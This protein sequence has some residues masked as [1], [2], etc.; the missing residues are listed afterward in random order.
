[1]TTSLKNKA[2][3]G[4]SWI[5]VGTLGQNSLQLLSLMV[6][7]RLLTPDEFGVVSVALVIIGFLRIFTELGVGPAVVQRLELT[8]S[9]ISTANTLAVTL[10]VIVS[11]LL[12]LSA[13]EISLFFNMSELERVVK[14]LSL[15]IPASSLA[16]VGQSLLQRTLK[17]RQIAI[18]NF[19]SFFVGYACIAVPM[20]LLECGVWS[21]VF[22]HLGQITAMNLIV[23]VFVKEANYYGF[24]LRSAKDLL[25]YGVGY[26][27]AKLSNFIA[28]EGDNIVVGKFLGASAL[29]IY[30]NSYRLMLFPA[31]LIGGV[32]DKV[33]FP[34]L[35]NM[36][37][38]KGRIS[39]V[40]IDILSIAT[41]LLVPVSIYLY[42][43][44]NEIIV[45]VLGKQWGDAVIVF[46]LLIIVLSFRLNYKFSDL[47]AAALGAVYRR[48]N[49]QII[50]ALAVILG[51]YVGH[52][53][54]V[55]GVAVGV[56][57]AIMLN[58][59]VM[60]QLSQS[61]IGFSWVDV[62]LMHF[63]QLCIALPIVL[64]TYLSRRYFFDGIESSLFI[65][66]F[67]GF[68]FFLTTLLIWL[69]FA[70]TMKREIAIF[71]FTLSRFLR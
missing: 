14:V 29:G 31:S 32:I 68:L 56:G 7:A 5:F 36:Q 67:S 45:L 59:V 25:G 53:F 27:L 24:N 46:Q 65:L 54:G 38:D 63:K 69:V 52:F 66:F 8:K 37:G 50:Y 42:F 26:S 9:H 1:M 16:V 19:L 70:K 61:L 23:H 47:L 55:E 30:S 43:F 6:L 58:Y 35:S 20:A 60:L 64:F 40:Y 62:A 17:F 10:G 34:I 28:G 41:M 48:A 15:M 39:K 12:Y 33:L 18:Y 11:L 4:F 2:L 22:A 13:N 49:R 21:L 57:F 44:A 71:K 3:K 51:A